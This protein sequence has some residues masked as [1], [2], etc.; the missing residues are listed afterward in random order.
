MMTTLKMKSKSLM[1]WT[2]VQWDTRGG[3]SKE[4]EVEGASNDDE[5]LN[6]LHEVHPEVPRALEASPKQCTEYSV[7]TLS[8][9]SLCQRTSRGKQQEWK[10]YQTNSMAHQG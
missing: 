5:D 10:Y 4:E 1:N 7:E 6:L 3:R 2:L 9:L 8:C